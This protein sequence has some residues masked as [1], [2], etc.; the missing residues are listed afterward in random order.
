MFSIDVPL[1]FAYTAGFVA[2]FNPCGAAMLP[3]YIGYQL[4]S[5]RSSKGLISTTFFALLLGFT[6]SLGFVVVF[7]FVGIILVAGG[8]VI[9]KLLPFAGLGVGIAITLVGVY[10]LLSKRKLFIVAASRVNLGEG[11][12]FRQ[13]FLFGIAYAIASLSCALPI[14]L[15]AIGIVAGQSLSAGTILETM[16]GSISYGL[17]MGTVLVTVTLGVVFFKHL[18]QRVVRAVFPIIEPLGNIAMIIAGIYLVHYWT[19]GKGSELL[20]LR[21]EQLF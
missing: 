13:M 17:G 6:A 14:F 16:L 9:S 2:A 20:F 5:V 3:A 19:F 10:L 11:T 8:R 15:A 4:D 21:A 12:G 7:G 18:V 1:V